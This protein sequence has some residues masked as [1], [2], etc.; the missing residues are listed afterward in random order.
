M[1]RL[2]STYTDVHH[3]IG[4]TLPDST[5]QERL[6]RR[7]YASA[8]LDMQATSMIE[9]HGTGTSAGDPIEASAIARAFSSRSTE[10]PLYVGA[11]KSGTGHLEGAAGVA[12]VIK[13]VLVLEEGIIPRNVNFEKVNPK[14]PAKRW[15]LQF[16]TKSV[17]WPTQ[18][19]RRI[20]I[21][22]FG[23]GG[24][25]THVVLDDA[26]NYLR[27]RGLVA[28]HNTNSQTP[29]EDE[30]ARHEQSLDSASG[31]VSV[32]QSRNIE[33]VNGSAYEMSSGDGDQSTESCETTNGTNGHPDAATGNSYPPTLVII[34]AFDEDGVLRNAKAQTTYL[35]RKSQTSAAAEAAF[36]RDYAYTMSRRTLF[37]W[38]RFALGQTT[39]EIIDSLESPA[40]VV[41]AR[42]SLQVGFVFTGQ[43]AQYSAM[44]QE[45]LIYPVFQA[46]L[47]DADMYFR[48]LGAS[49]SLLEELARS[50]ES[51]NIAQAYLAQPACTAIQVAIVELLR[52]WN[53]RPSRV[54]GHSSGEFAAAF[55]AGKLDRETAWR[56]AYLRGVVRDQKT[57]SAGAMM[58]VGLS[59][60]GLQHY[61]EQ[62]HAC[63]VGRLVIA[64]L[65]SSKNNTVSG[66]KPAIDALQHLLD[67]DGVF[68]RRLEVANAYHSHHM[69]ALA[70]EYLDLLSE[71]PSK[72]AAGDESLV[73]MFSTV[74]GERIVRTNGWE[75][76]LDEANLITLCV[77][78]QQ[79]PSHELTQSIRDLFKQQFVEALPVENHHGEFC[80]TADGRILT[81]RLHSSSKGDRFLTSRFSKLKPVMTPLGS[82]GRPI[83]LSAAVP[84]LLNR[85]EWVNDEHYNKPLGDT[86]VEIDIKAVGLN[87]R[88]LMIAMGEHM[89]W[90]IGCE[91]SGII[92]RTGPWVQHLKVGDRVMYIAGSDNVGCFHTYGRL[93]ELAV[94]K[95]PDSLSFEDAAG[96]CVVYA[97][98]IASLRDAG[99]PVKG[100]K[101]LIHAAAG[102]VGQAAIR[103][104]QHIGAEVF[105]TVS[106]LEKRDILMTEHNIPEDHIFSSRDL[107][108]YNGIKRATG[109]KGVDV[110][111]NSLSG[112][113]LRRSW[114]LLSPF[115][116]FVE[117]GKKDAQA[118]GCIELTPFLRNVTM[119]SVDFMIMMKHRPML[120]KQLTEDTIRLWEQGVAKPAVPTK[121]M[122]MSQVQEGLSILQGGKGAGKIIFVLSSEDQ[123]PIVPAQPLPY[124]FR[125]DATYVLSGGLGG[126]GRSTAKWMASRGARNLVF[127]SSSGRITE[128]VSKMQSDLEAEGCSV[129]IFKCDVSDAEQLRAVIE[130]FASSLPPIK[131]LIQGAMHLKDSMLGNMSWEDYQTAI[132]PKV[133]G[134]W[135]LHEILP[136]DLDFFVMLSSAT[137]ILGNR[138]QANYAAGN[139]FQ[140]QLAYHR[141]SLGLPASTLD[142]GTVLSVGYIAEN[143]G[144]VAVA[145]NAGI[146][147]E[148]IREEEVHALIELLIG[149][150]N[151]PPPQMFAGL[152]TM[153]TYRSRG[154]PPP[155]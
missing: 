125:Q 93:D 1:P 126:I 99:R 79:P 22:S 106:S 25:N 112:E 103:Y 8:G 62:V 151:D 132:K 11:V 2:A 138:A 30:I 90:S 101:V 48:S 82:A 149:P 44:G 67:N 88:D 73:H 45:L 81:S 19:L 115:G 13:A 118:H 53:V 3:R 78:N 139:V 9:A 121:I 119:T 127:L 17:P 56:I 113:A 68:A 91:A 27:E 94:V 32:S 116:R 14:I 105:A 107:T 110:V 114:E 86:E 145:R 95:I 35:K 24:T 46:S 141:R 89:A 28:V 134:S 63:N 100:E 60:D 154:I 33:H 66:D 15:N 123:I 104:A 37:S 55:A 92:S 120:I 122:P 98:V 74:T 59:S 4:L 12:G 71:V 148:L 84:G 155:T 152:T 124:R 7:V 39:S 52:S 147:L 96:L 54:V 47:L 128:A 77:G 108:F 137:G 144:R 72:A 57:N 21:N 64:C 65:N 102:G 51:S 43:G 10:N 38:R 6:M 85:L 26:Y 83:K 40:K 135:N 140:D 146:T 16:P 34:S 143:K 117:I 87:F 49:W 58:A 18:G 142:L 5:A 133:Q 50:D 23:V 136:K 69:Q 41:K 150:R 109:G 61:I 70:D 130:S 111:L 153:D 29:I 129:H 76:D 42:R 20:S 75:S 80:L 131:G 31:T 36:L 97:T